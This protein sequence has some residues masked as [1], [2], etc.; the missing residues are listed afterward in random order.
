MPG[1]LDSAMS[2]SISWQRSTALII[3]IK[4]CSSYS[5]ALT[6]KSY[7]AIVYIIM[8]QQSIYFN[9][10]GSGNKQNTELCTEDS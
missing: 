5:F 3:I 6:D 9:H 8:S 4:N 2:L 10:A 1:G 7:I